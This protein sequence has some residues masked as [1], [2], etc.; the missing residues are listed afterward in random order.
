MLYNIVGYFSL[1]RDFFDPKL[2]GLGLG[3]LLNT[4]MINVYIHW[5]VI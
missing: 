5:T 4:E 3:V 2:A 1:V